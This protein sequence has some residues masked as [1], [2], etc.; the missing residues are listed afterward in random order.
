MLPV[1]CERCALEWRLAW[2]QGWQWCYGA[3]VYFILAVTTHWLIQ[4]LMPGVWSQVGW[5]LVWVLACLSLLLTLQTVCLPDAE[6][7]AHAL[8]CV[9]AAPRWAR[10]FFKYLIIWFFSIFPLGVISIILSWMLVVPWVMSVAFLVSG[11][12]GSWLILGLGLG[13][14][15]LSSA[16]RH[17]S[18][19]LILMTVPL[20]I[21]VIFWGAGAIWHHQMGLSAAYEWLMLS[22]LSVCGVIVFPALMSAAVKI[23]VDA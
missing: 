14:A 4:G 20:Y 23:G 5:A 17:H 13:I 9:R 11:V 18:N 1:W 8:W 10:M 21:P 15:Q 2:R 22:G 7:E 6:Y 12:L 16:L 3:G 19:L